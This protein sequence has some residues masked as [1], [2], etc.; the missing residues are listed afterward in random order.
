MLPTRYRLD[1]TTGNDGWWDFQLDG[2]GTLAVGADPPR[3][4][5]RRAA[6]W[7]TAAALVVVYL[8]EFWH[9]PCYDWWEENADVRHTATLAAVRA[10]LA[11]ALASPAV[12]AQLESPRHRAGSSRSCTAST[13]RCPAQARVASR[14]RRRTW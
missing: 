8:A 7:T 1:G 14:G 12:A 9:L 5:R 6:E 3:R 4:R 10:G 11:A 2:Y 13:P